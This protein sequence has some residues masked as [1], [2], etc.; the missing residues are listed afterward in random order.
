MP[1]Q[2]ADSDPFVPIG[3]PLRATVSTLKRDR[4]RG[5]LLLETVLG[6]IVSSVESWDGTAR[7][8]GPAEFEIEFPEIRWHKPPHPPFEGTRWARINGSETEHRIQ[9]AAE[10]RSSLATPVLAIVLGYLA[11]AT[12]AWLPVWLR[13]LGSLI[14]LGIFWLRY[15][16]AF[17]SG[18]KLLFPR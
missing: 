7:T 5:E 11:A 9:L 17:R 13:P 18:L 6:R 15:W 14:L 3:L 16:F 10:G 8:T 12:V 4:R 2:H 1:D